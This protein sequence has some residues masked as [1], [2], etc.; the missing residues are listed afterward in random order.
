MKKQ[1]KKEKQ[2]KEEVVLKKKTYYAVNDR[3]QDIVDQDEIWLYDTIE[4]AYK[5]H[6]DDYGTEG[7]SYVYK[8]EYM[9]EVSME[10]II[11]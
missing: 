2:P 10:L 3:H 7:E 6:I 8:I 11:K 5:K 1:I 9:G 4:E